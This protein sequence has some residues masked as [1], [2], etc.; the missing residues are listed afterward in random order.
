MHEKTEFILLDLCLT[1][2]TGSPCFYNTLSRMFIPQIVSLNSVD[3]LPLLYAAI[4][5]EFYFWTNECGG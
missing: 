1:K 2:I 3:L 4:K 5:T